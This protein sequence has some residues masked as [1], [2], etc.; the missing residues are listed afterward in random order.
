[1]RQVLFALIPFLAW[2]LSQEDPVVFHSSTRLVEVQITVRNQRIRPPGVRAALVWA[3]DSGPPFGPAGTPVR[4]LTKDD[5]ILLDQG[6]PQRIAV[7]GTQQVHEKTSFPLAPG[8]VSNR[9]DYRGEPLAGATAVLVDLLNTPWQLSDYARLGMTE[10]VRTL[11]DT[12]APIAL[13]SLGKELHVLHDFTDDPQKL[14]DVAAFLEESHG[15]LPPDFSTA[16][17]DYGYPPFDKSWVAADRI[18]RSALTSVIQHLSGFA[19]RKS[20]VW[21]SQAPRI[22]PEMM[23]RM[24]QANIALYPVRVRGLGGFADLEG[25]VSRELGNASGGRGFFDARDL[26]FA[27]QAATEDSIFAYVVGYYPDEAML[28]GKFHKV[29]VKLADQLLEVHYRSGYLATTDEVPATMAKDAPNLAELMESPM[30]SSGIGLA[31]R[32]KQDIG[33]R[34]FYEIP[35]TV[36]LHDVKLERKA[37]HFVGKLDFTIPGLSSQRNIRTGKVTLDL[38]DAQFAW[39]LEQG[40]TFTIKGVEFNTRK[41]LLVV[42]D[43]ATGAA[44]SLLVTLPNESDK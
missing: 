20:L 31:A 15:H 44:G 7:F 2:A 6:K 43:H 8:Y 10:L 36:D 37:D 14:R 16:L 34:D 26:A 19:G 32:A 35:V 3:L 29:T 38:T 17:E 30:N 33:N 4:G 41:I 24:Q 21:L 27:V 42:R 22:P 39:A 1:L 11:K 5:F 9:S 13:Y 23:R 28:D 40:Y 25:E 18:T 12:Q